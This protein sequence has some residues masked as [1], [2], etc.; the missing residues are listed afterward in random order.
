MTTLTA[1][2]T[3][4]GPAGTPVPYRPAGTADVLRAEWAK[5]RS[6]RST[7]W[8]L[9]ALV[10]VSVG[11]TGLVTWAIADELASG[12]A[13]E[14]P[15]MF[16]TWGIT[17][18]QIA[19]LVLGT[20]VITSEYASGTI[21]PSLAAV[22]RRMRLLGAKVAVLA[23]V[24][25]VL[26]LAVS[27]ASYAVGDF[28]LSRE[29]V[30]VPLSD[31]G[32]LRALVGNALYLSVLAVFGLG[33]GLVLRHTA[34]A[35]TVGIALVFVVGQLVTLLPGT[36]GEWVAKLMPGNA[37]SAVTTVVP[38]DPDQLG[39]WTGFG[40]FALETALLVALGAVLLARRDA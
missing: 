18:G 33:L 2:T 20:L 15:A 4:P 17:F 6:V 22:P 1:P 10:V 25:L 14:L 12:E 11:L 37:G 23:A 38:W 27:F 36:V 26:G 5:L 16:V 9:A 13:G 19:A 32:V 31:D 3:P 35:V 7:A 30:G 21:R 8:T 40:V 34:A 39:P 24:M 28:F 29:G